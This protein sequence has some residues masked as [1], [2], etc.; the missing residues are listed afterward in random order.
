[1]WR[2]ARGLGDKVDGEGCG[3]DASDDEVAGVKV[4]RDEADGEGAQ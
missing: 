3:D 4:H 1:M 2:I